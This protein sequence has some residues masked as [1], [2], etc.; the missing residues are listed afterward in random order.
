MQKLSFEEKV[1][2]ASLQGIVNKDGPHVFVR[3]ND[4]DD[5]WADYYSSHYDVRFINLSDPYQLMNIFANKIKG[6]VLWGYDKIDGLNVAA[7][8]AGLNNWLIV[9]PVVEK[10]AIL[11]G[12]PLKKDLRTSLS[13]M[14]KAQIYDWAFKNYWSR[15]NKKF[16]SSLPLGDPKW[17]SV[18]I[19]PYVN[20]ENFYIRFEDAIKSDGN[21]AKLRCLKI[22][23]DTEDVV[24]FRTGTAEEKK[25]LYDADN[26]W[27]DPDGDR[28]ADCYQYFTYRFQLK[29]SKRLLLKFLAFNQYM[30]K[31]GNS[32]EGPFTT[33]AF[34]TIVTGSNIGVNREL[35][36]AVNYRTFCFD[37]SSRENEYPD[38]YAVKEKIMESMEHP[39]IVL[40][41]VSF[42]TGRD[43]EGTYVSQASKHGNCVIC[44]GAPN[45]S[46]HRWIKP[47]EFTPPTL[48]SLPQIDTSKIYVSFLLS[49]GDALHWVSGFQ[50]KQWL[51]PN[52][53]SIPFGWEIQPLLYDLAPAMLQYY[54]ETATNNDYLVAAA[55]GIGYCHPE[56]FPPDRLET[57]LQKSRSYLKLT[58][59]KAISILSAGNISFDVALNY[60]KYFK[61]IAVGCEEGYSGRLPE[62]GYQFSD[63]SVWRTRIPIN[64]EGTKEDILKELN[65]VAKSTLKRPLFIPVHPCCYNTNIDGVK[66][67]IDKLDPDVFQIV[68]PGQ[69]LKMVSNFYSDKL[70][71]IHPLEVIALLKNRPLFF[72]VQF[73][74]ITENPV[75]VNVRLNIPKGVKVTSYKNEVQ[76]KQDK[77][78]KVEFRL[79]TLATP[80][81]KS[82]LGKAQLK[83]H[84]SLFDEAFEFPT[85]LL[86][87]Q[88]GPGNYF[89]YTA[90]WDAINMNHRFGKRVSDSTAIGGS[91]W[92]AGENMSAS[93]GHCVFG[94]YASLPAGNYV[95]CFRLK[96]N[97]KASAE[98][99]VID[100][101]NLAAG[102]ITLAQKYIHGSD[103]GTT[104]KYRFFYLPFKHD[105]KGT[106]ETRVYS[107]GSCDL[108]ID[109][110]IIIQQKKI[111]SFDGP[112][113]GMIGDTLTFYA[114]AFTPNG[115]SVSVRF[116]WGDG[117]TT[118]WSEYQLS[119]Y[120]FVFSHVWSDTGNFPVKFQI[121]DIRQNYVNWSDLKI[122]TISSGNAGVGMPFGNPRKFSLSQNYPNPFNHQTKIKFSIPRAEY[123]T[124]KIYNMLGKEVAVLVSDHF[125]AGTYETRWN[126]K[127]IE[128]SGVYICRMKA[129]KFMKTKKLLFLK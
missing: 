105:G 77:L 22:I 87:Y 123:V 113:Q 47:G 30:I 117:D 1:L 61:D 79:D 44:C 104:G 66:W 7:T 94:P 26:S 125:P 112:T 92:F 5:R 74:A 63:F 14:N 41:W 65:H 118:N 127:N 116:A 84:S 95:A 23:T 55:S 129:G 126:A 81:E 53:G 106:I 8:L 82:L 31:V 58:G 80:S 39:G 100:V 49:D 115:D 36:M 108:W 2:F 91:A 101:F 69:L 3:Y 111:G 27:F 124:L 83:F 90:G 15:C 60:R 121:R 120:P 24:N 28:I 48:K 99:A 119:G 110:I 32:P 13:G 16:V 70:V 42:Q 20:K 6:Y 78:S 4:S 98:A 72:P 73:R 75:Q 54:Y 45:M 18:N 57:Y 17:V 109:E 29:D 89:I 21:G 11:K 50:G 38:E 52:R 114:N 46:F 56:E 10:Y 62:G 102:D 43:D 64:G 33:V 85:I 37:L 103:F 107:M 97:T 35:D 51:S 40:G 25:Y 76:S 12:I 34:K 9:S 59:L 122:V 71:L 68:Q 19:G 86:D 88:P 67:I 128:C 93:P 96:S